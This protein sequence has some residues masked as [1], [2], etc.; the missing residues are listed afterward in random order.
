MVLFV[1][2]R[3][4]LQ[5]LDGF[6]GRGLG[7]VDLL[8]AARQRTIPLE[9]P[10]LAVGRGA[11]A[12]YLTGLEQR[13]E[14]VRGV[15]GGTL[16]GPGAQDGV[17]LV[18]EEDRLVAL[19]HGG[20]QRLEAGLEV[21]PIAGTRQHRAQVEREDL[22]G[23]HLLGDATLVDAPGQTFS[24]RRLAHSGLADEQ[25]VVLASPSQHMDRAF[26]LRI[27]T[28]EGVELPLG[29]QLG[30]VGREGL[31]G[32]R[33]ALAIFVEVGIATEGGRLAVVSGGI[34]RDSVRDEAKHVE[35]RYALLAQ[36]RHRV[37]VGLLEDGCQQVPGFDDLLLGARRVLQCA[38][39]HPVKRQGLPQLDGILAGLLL[40]VTLEVGL[41]AI[42][43]LAD[44]GP[45]ALEDARAVAVEGER[46][47]EMLHGQ[48][49]VAP[50]HGLASSG[51]DRELEL[52]AEL[53]H[54]FSIPARKG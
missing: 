47:E 11:D 2:G 6:L 51:L 38:L 50:R 42:L 4:A 54:S 35:A 40:E 32:I 3:E 9:V 36:E 52:A 37:G 43:Q 10:E 29:S 46:V 28:H 39:E 7:D 23:L 26:D 24:Q 53:T 15:H 27:A 44:V 16:G 5:D 19:A 12:A 31:E 17:N 22:G 13:L 21:A 34:L 30:Q 25:R 1:A 18:D 45:A 14:H 48:I 41:E 49:G 20:H 8:E 33:G